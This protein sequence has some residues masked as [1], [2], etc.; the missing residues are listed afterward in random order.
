MAA[1]SS[2]ETLT[3]A[4][5]GYFRGRALCAAARLGVADALGLGERSAEELAAD[6]R[7]DPAALRRLLRALASFGI[8]AETQPGLFRLTERGKPLRKDDPRS[9]WAA[10]VFWA[11]LLADDWR[12]LTECVRAGKPARDAR[13]AGEP[14]RWDED[15]EAPQIFRAV[16]GTA[17]AEDYM[18]IARAWDFSKYRTVAD[19]GCGGGALTEAVL[20]TYPDVRAIL[21]DRSESLEKASARLIAEGL[22]TRCDFLAADLLESV[23][24]GA[25]AHILKSVL[26]GYPDE[27]AAAILRRCRAALPADG[28]LLLVESVLPEVIDRPDADLEHK[29]MSDLNML[30]ATGG[31]ER[32]ETEWKNLLDEAGFDTLSST[33]A[34][35]Q[36]AAILEAA[37]RPRKAADKSRREAAQP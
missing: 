19:L 3:A 17:P 20:R 28:R 29:L 1:E 31:R 21:V 22:D 27:D 33:G 30:V 37:P 13:P 24:S 9:E 5:M 25:D 18:P 4:A 15:P 10:V 34:A 12:R 14:G 7:A 36:P 32:T 2:G 6:C 8:A 23:P 16:M 26:H 35:P 11:D